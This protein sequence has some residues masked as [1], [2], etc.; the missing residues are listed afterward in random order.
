LEDANSKCYLV[1]Y[2]DIGK[3][4]NTHPKRVWKENSGHH[5]HG[6]EDIELMGD[7]LL[8]VGI[9]Y[10]ASDSFIRKIFASLKTEVLDLRSVDYILRAYG[11]QWDFSGQFQFNEFIN[12]LSST[13]KHH[14]KLTLTK[15]ESEIP[16]DDNHILLVVNAALRRLVSSFRA[17]ILLSRHGFY[18]EAASVSRLILEQLGW[19]YC[20]H[21][22]EFEQIEKVEAN[23]TISKLKNLV[24]EAGKVNGFLNSAT[25]MSLSETRKYLS[26]DEDNIIVRLMSRD[27]TQ[28]IAFY[29]LWLVDA[30]SLVTESIAV[31]YGGR[32]SNLKKNQ[33]GNLVPNGDR[34]LRMEL[35][36]YEK[37]LLG[38]ID[39]RSKEEPLPDR[40]PPKIEL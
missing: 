32:L 36:A 6:I 39:E 15:F 40:K 27:D 38:L 11:D 37:R 7:T 24:P 16:Q 25:H 9:P 26:I 21:K 20:V 18:F 13:I 31:E 10:N 28:V 30:L 35:K 29:L 2:M 4:P 3:T 17:G 22:L 8:T 34:I 33:N 14:L 23:K 1:N 5:S 12:D 19:I